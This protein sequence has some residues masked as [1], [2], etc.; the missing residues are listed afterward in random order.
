LIKDDVALGRVASYLNCRVFKG[1]FRKL[2]LPVALF[3]QNN[4]HDDYVS[5][6][7]AP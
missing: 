2:R 7:E 1:A 3:Y 6:G 5:L 4:F